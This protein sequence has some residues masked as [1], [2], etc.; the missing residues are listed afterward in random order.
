MTDVPPPS[1][2]VSPAP[3]PAITTAPAEVEARTWTII[4]YGLYLAALV[5]G[6]LSGIVG[7]VMAY[8]KREEFRGTIWESHAENAIRA[9]WVWFLL[10][11]ASIPLMLLFGLGVI[12]MFGAFAYF[13]FRTIKGLIA[14]IDGKPYV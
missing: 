8:I 13:L 12:V 14:A 7:V 1:S 5:C 4:I 9:F 11:V 10:F 3:L 6:G 2:S